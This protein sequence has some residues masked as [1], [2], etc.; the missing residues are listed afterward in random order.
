ML[1]IADH[2]EQLGDH[3]LDGKGPWHYDGCTRVPFLIRYP[4]AFPAGAVVD[5]F[6]SQCDVA[7]TVC[8][9]AGVP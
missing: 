4:P 8:E 1:A 9:L 2:G 5:G 7:P 6:V 3:W